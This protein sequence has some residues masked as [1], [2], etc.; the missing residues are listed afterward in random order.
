MIQLGDKVRILNNAYEGSTDP[1]DVAAR[2]LVGEVRWIESDGRIEV[3]TDDDW[4]PLTVDEVE[5]IPP[6]NTPL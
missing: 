5:V 4:Y 6:L 2:G 1:D 3:F